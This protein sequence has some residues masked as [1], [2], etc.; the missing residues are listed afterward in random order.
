MKTIAL[1]AGKGALPPMLVTAIKAKGH[2][3][4]VVNLKGHNEVPIE[5]P[6]VDASTTLP[7]G[8]VSKAIRFLKDQS[9][10]EVLF[11]GNVDKTVWYRDLRP[12][13]EALKLI[14]N[15]P[16]GGDDRILRAVSDMLEAKGFQVGA[17]IDWLPDCLAPQGHL[18]GPKASHEVIQDMVFGLHIAQGIG[19]LEIGQTAVV[20][21]G[22]VV[23]VEAVEGT[24]AM[25]ERAGSLAKKDAVVVKA[26]KPQQDRRLDVPT[27]GVATLMVM[28]QAGLRWLA[29][30]A[31]CLILE[32]EVFR[33]QA[34]ALNI[35]V[36]GR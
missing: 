8:A 24:D 17:P 4:C 28:K 34:K 13:L 1:I 14:R 16:D 25:L 29:L 18:A 11:A 36:Y 15:L 6:L 35:G 19:T 22:C 2:R 3:L 12:D 30:E 5:P 23:A 31:G 7:V 21:R 10:D 9:A 20:C 33:A 26:I 27:V 32:P